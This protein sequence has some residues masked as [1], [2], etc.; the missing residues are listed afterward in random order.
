MLLHIVVFMG[1]V[2]HFVVCHDGYSHRTSARE[3]GRRGLAPAKIDHHYI[4]FPA[5]DVAVRAPDRLHGTNSILYCPSS[6]SV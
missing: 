4:V 6:D 3:V 2:E 1:A 5:Y